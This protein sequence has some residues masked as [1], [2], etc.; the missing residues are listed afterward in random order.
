[1]FI[2]LFVIETFL[3]TIKSETLNKYK[4]TIHRIELNLTRHYLKKKQQKTLKKL[5]TTARKEN[6]TI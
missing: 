1:M 6:F 5:F 4:K 2:V 3:S